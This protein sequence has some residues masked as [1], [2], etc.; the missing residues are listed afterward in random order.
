MLGL[1]FEIG[2]QSRSYKWTLQERSPLLHQVPSIE[3]QFGDMQSQLTR[4]VKLTTA[5]VRF[6]EEKA[7]QSQKGI[8]EKAAQ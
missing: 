5:V 2:L 3:S 6:L 7:E 1:Q 4:W 8:L